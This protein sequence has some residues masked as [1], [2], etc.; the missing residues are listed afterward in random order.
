MNWS[1][2]KKGDGFKLFVLCF[3]KRLVLS[4]TS[5]I[6]IFIIAATVDKL[7]VLFFEKKYFELNGTCFLMRVS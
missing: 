4:P 1:G 7:F 3:M 6:R 2:V 5:S